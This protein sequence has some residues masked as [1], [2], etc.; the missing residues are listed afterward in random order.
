MCA[1]VVWSVTKPRLALS[2]TIFSIYISLKHHTNTDISFYITAQAGGADAEFVFQDGMY[3]GVV[4]SG[5]FLQGHLGPEALPELCRVIRPG[6]F[7]VFT[8]SI[9]EWCIRKP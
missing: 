6:G 1:T 8:V 9:V 5:T 4:S 7:M 2:S 3:A